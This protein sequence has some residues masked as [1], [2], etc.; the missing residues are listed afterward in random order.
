[1]K[2]ARVLVTGA[3]GL[4][5]GRLAA[6]LAR[7]ADV[8]AARHRDPAPEGLPEVSLDLLSDASVE[9]AFDAVR[10]SAVLHSAA[11][12]NPDAMEDTPEAARAHNVDGTARVARAARRHGARLVALSTD[13]VLG[14]G[15]AWSDESVPANPLL[16]YGR[17]K[18]QGEVAALAECAGAVVVRVPLVV[19]RGNG[20]R[21]T[22]SETIVEGLR[23]GRPLR[24]FTDQ[25][26]TPVDPESLADLI[27]RLLVSTVTGPVHAGGPERVSRYELGL[28]VA[29]VFGLPEGGLVPILQ[30]EGSLG[31]RRPADTSLDIT[32]ARR[33][34]GWEPRPMDVALAESRG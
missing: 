23:A 26:R 6:L 5:G 9:A 13:L 7:S 30:A 28:R 8:V 29:R 11:L 31:A 25:Y 22:A 14:G 24:L 15:R 32:R 27:E 20:P 19:G 1:M 2:R 12:S 34:L 16:V 3:S 21:R 10:P 33:E 18:Y 17:T 4:L